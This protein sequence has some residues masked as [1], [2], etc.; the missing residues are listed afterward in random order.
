MFRTLEVI[1]VDTSARRVVVTAAKLKSNMLSVNNIR[2]SHDGR[3]IAFD[4]RTEDEAAKSNVAVVSY[5]GGALRWLTRDG[6]SK[7]PHWSADGRSV[8]YIR[9]DSEIRSVDEDGRNDRLLSSLA[10][11]L[12]SKQ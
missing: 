2:W 3:S 9:A 8:L 1:D 5:P 6:K 10:G 12:S 4:F 11:C 7:L